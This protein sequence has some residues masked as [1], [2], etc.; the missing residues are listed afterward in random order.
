MDNENLVAAREAVLIAHL[1]AVVA[2]L[3]KLVILRHHDVVVLEFLVFIKD[4]QL[5]VDLRCEF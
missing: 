2:F 3:F 1:F 5:D 4:T